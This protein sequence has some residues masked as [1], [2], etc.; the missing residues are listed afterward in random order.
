[1]WT[2]RRGKEETLQ[3]LCHDISRMAGLAFLEKSSYHR[4]I[5]ETYAFIKANIEGRFRMKIRD[6]EPKDL[7][8]ALHIA[9]LGEANTEDRN[10]AKTVE[11]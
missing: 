9:L 7:D 5:T 3:V 1:M 2:R 11:S 10:N 4:E 6:K 8:Q